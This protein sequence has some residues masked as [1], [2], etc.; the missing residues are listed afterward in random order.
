MCVSTAVT[1]DGEMH[2][3]V[4]RVT[5]LFL[6]HITPLHCQNSFHFS[7]SCLWFHWINFCLIYLVYFWSTLAHPTARVRE[8]Q[9]YEILAEAREN[10]FADD[11]ALV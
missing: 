7:P 1:G 10:K 4:G 3:G 8:P 5:G 9:V 6:S 2:L 11:T